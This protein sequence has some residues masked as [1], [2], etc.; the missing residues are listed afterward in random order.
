M[1]KRIIK[2]TELCTQSTTVGLSIEKHNEKKE[3]INELVD[4]GLMTFDGMFH[5][6]NEEDRNYFNDEINKVKNK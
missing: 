2:L 1:D 3:L 6:I 4:E 5:F